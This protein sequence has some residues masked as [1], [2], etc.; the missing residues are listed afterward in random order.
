MAKN[1]AFEDGELEALLKEANAPIV[2]PTITEAFKEVAKEVMK[3][4]AKTLA[5]LEDT[6]MEQAFGVCKNDLGKWDVVEILYNTK[7]NECRIND[8][9]RSEASKAVA[10][11]RAAE[12]MARV[13]NGLSL[14]SMNKVKQ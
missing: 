7:T 14:K 1:K 11:A 6:K 8:I 12:A 3:T 4:H 10:Q 5:K 13:L 9:I 2:K